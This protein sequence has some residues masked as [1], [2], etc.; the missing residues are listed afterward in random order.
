M[1][2]RYILISGLGSSSERIEGRGIMTPAVAK[3]W[4]LETMA[5]RGVPGQTWLVLGPGHTIEAR[6]NPAD[7]AGGWVT[8]HERRREDVQLKA[9]PYW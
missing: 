9:C 4:L 6:W 8:L 7:I 3:A 1:N 5:R 2:K